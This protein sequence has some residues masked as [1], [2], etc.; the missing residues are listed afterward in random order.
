MK[1]S[2]NKFNGKSYTELMREAERRK[3][4][5]YRITGKIDKAERTIWFIIFL[6]MFAISVHYAITSEYFSL[7]SM[8]R[9][10]YLKYLKLIFSGTIFSVGKLFFEPEL[11]FPK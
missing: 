8:I 6:L 9:S 1:F 11:N 3:T 4:E 2:N 7:E 10:E 5:Y